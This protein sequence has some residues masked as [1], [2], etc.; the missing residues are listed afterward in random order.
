MPCTAGS[1]TMTTESCKHDATARVSCEFLWIHG[2]CDY[3][4][5]D[6]HHIVCCL[7]AGLWLRL[8]LMSGWS[9]V[10]HMYLYDLP[11]S[12]SHCLCYVAWGNGA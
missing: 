5:M 10:M 12:L 1:V 3:I 4:S 9:V 8:D 6:A 11:L 7:V 2:T